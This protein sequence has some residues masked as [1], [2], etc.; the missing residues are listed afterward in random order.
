MTD[1]YIVTVDIKGYDPQVAGAYVDKAAAYLVADAIDRLEG[2]DAASVNH[3]EVNGMAR[4]VDFEAV[5]R[6]RNETADERNALAACFVQAM[7]RLAK[8]G[9]DTPIGPGSIRPSKIAEMAAI[10]EAEVTSCTI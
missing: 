2:I 6:Q 3:A 1:I 9:D 8:L 7:E 10:H 5:A 4:R